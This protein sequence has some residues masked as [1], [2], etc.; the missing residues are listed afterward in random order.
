[1]LCCRFLVNHVDGSMFLVAAY[2]SRLVSFISFTEAPFWQTLHD[3]W[4][5]VVGFGLR[6]YVG[7][8]EVD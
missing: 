7:V 8:A 5:E 6:V 1:M 2:R 4:V 3:L